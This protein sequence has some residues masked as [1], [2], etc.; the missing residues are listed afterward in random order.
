MI[1]KKYIKFNEKKEKLDLS[2][3]KEE[4]IKINYDLNL[5]N[6]NITKVKYYSDLG[7]DIFNINDDFFNDIFFSFSMNN[8]DIILN[9]R[10]NEI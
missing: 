7:I 3:C 9:D 1:L 10:V 5:S 8:S 2:V 6:I 4:N